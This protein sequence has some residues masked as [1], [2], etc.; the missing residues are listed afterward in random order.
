MGYDRP[1]EDKREITGTPS[2]ADAQKLHDEMRAQTGEN[3]VTRYRTY[4]VTEVTMD[5]GEKLRGQPRNHTPYTYFGT[6]REIPDTPYPKTIADVKRVLTNAPD[7]W[8]LKNA[9][10]LHASFQQALKK[11]KT[12]IIASP[13]VAVMYEGKGSKIRVF[14]RASGA[15]VWPLAKAAKAPK[16]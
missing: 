10:S 11:G 12:H 4:T 2:A 14:N 7:A 5:D 13:G 8:E 6:V 3:E 1:F 9:Q 16:P 15:Q